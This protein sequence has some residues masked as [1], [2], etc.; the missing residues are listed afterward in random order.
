MGTTNFTCMQF[1][2][3]HNPKLRSPWPWQY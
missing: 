1:L 2:H 3:F